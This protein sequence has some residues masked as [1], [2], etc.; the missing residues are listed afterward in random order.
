MY[1]CRENTDKM[2]LSNEARWAQPLYSSSS[3]RILTREDNE[4][5]SAN[6]SCI[7]GNSSAI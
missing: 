6:D 2:L 7:S 4:V 3:L 5:L 1:T